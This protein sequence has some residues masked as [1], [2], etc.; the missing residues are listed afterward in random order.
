VVSKWGLQIAACTSDYALN[1][2]GAILSCN[3]RHIGC[4]AHSLNLA[5]QH[6]LKKVQEI[7]DK[8]KGILKEALKQWP[9]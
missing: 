6:A 1:I 9:N 8:V 7:R 5:V 4:F 2:T 3:W